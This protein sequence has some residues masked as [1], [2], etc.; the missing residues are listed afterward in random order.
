MKAIQE[1]QQT[2]QAFN[3]EKEAFV[4]RQTASD[5]EGKSM[6]IELEQAMSQMKVM[7]EEQAQQ[8][9]E[10][11]LVTVYVLLCW[12]VCVVVSWTQQQQQQPE[13]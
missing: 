5:G 12:G 3:K 6:A 7:R 10:Y 11:V 8:L 4:K 2:L 13:Q 1:H 9:V